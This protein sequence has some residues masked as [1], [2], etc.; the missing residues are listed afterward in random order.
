MR[1]DR[2]SVQCVL[3]ASCLV[4]AGLASAAEYKVNGIVDIRATNTDGFSESYINAGQGKFGLNDGTQLSIAQIG[5]DLSASWDNDISAHVV[6]NG[7]VDGEDDVL[8]VTEAY[9]KHRSLPNDGGYRFQS[10]AG[11]F[12]PEISLE[13]DAFAWATKNTLNSSMLNTWIGEEV[14]VLGSEIKIT[15]LGRLN[16]DSYDISLSGTAFVNNDPAGSLLAWHGWTMNTRQTLWTESRPLPWF[17][18]LAPDGPLAGQAK[19]SDPFIELDDRIGYHVRSEVKFHNKGE[20]SVGYYNNNAT[21]NIVKNGQYAWKTRFYHLGAHWRISDE[22]SLVAQYLNGDTLMQSPYKED[23]VNNDYATGFVSLT[24]KW[25]SIVNNKKHKSTIRI[26]EF[27]IDDNDMTWGD[28]NEENGHAITVNHHY[29]LTKQWFLSAE[30]NYIDSHR[31]ARYYT[32]Q[33]VDLIE[34]QFQL[35]ARYFF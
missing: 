3:F 5:A 17:P 30:F 26:E 21:P 1:I 7:Y 28:N 13:N 20:F 19:Q 23:V 4:P 29:R 14:R 35:A 11:I 18:A 15:R 33:D 24:Y 27:S 12:Y 2:N 22:L 25:H 32:H 34:K 6:V 31:P 16:N 10:K 9:L 8:G